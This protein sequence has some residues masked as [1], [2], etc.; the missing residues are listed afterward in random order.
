MPHN[1]PNAAPLPAPANPHLPDAIAALEDAMRRQLGALFSTGVAVPP[2]VEALVAAIDPAWL[3][4]LFEH[5]AR[6]P[7]PTRRTEDE[8]RRHLLTRTLHEA[9]RTLHGEARVRVYRHDA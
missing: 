4:Q 3:A 6:V 1:L 9:A 7:D 5:G 8:W 2:I